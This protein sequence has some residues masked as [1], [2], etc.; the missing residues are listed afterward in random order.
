MTFIRTRSIV[1]A[2]VA[3]TWVAVPAAASADSLPSTFKSDAAQSGDGGG[4]QSYPPAASLPSTFKSDSAQSGDGSGAQSY[5]PAASLPSTFK[6]D[7]AQSGDRGGAQPY[8][9]ADFRGGDM[10]V[11][12]PG[13][14]RAIAGAPTTIEVVRPERTIV[15]DADEALPVI[16]SSTA[17]LLALAGLGVM[18]VRFRPVPR[19]GRSH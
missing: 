11:D 2:I 17:L 8:A 15:R 3:A 10:P 6:S 5:A 16:L 12:H 9:P 19:P 1:A 4:A 18:L 14:S 13:A 7:A